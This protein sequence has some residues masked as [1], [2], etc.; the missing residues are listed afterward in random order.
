MLRYFVDGKEVTRTEWTSW[1]ENHKR[2]EKESLIR[3]VKRGI[4]S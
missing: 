4:V 3:W 1:Y 2:V